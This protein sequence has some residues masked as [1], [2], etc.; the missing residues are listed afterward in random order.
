MK[1]VKKLLA[2][3]LICVLALSCFAACGDKDGNDKSDS[4]PKVTDKEGSA[5]PTPVPSDPASPSTASLAGKVF[6]LY[7]IAG[8][9]G[10][11]IEYKKYMEDYMAEAGILP[12]TDEYEQALELSNATYTFKENG[13]LTA[14]ILGMDLEMEYTF[15]GTNGTISMDG[16]QLSTFVYDSAAGTLTDTDGE[17]GESQ[18]FKVVD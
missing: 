4:T 2:M 11:M 9:D 5:T 13:I 17:S 1:N 15:D 10:T 8:E 6:E 18:V 7:L 16:E 3:F 12:G 14:S